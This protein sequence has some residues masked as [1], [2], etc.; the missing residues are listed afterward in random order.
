MTN[1]RAEQCIDPDQHS[2]RRN[3]DAR[4]TLDRLN[5]DHD[6]VGNNLRKGGT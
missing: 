2:R 1:L 5:T 3:E 6:S 4:F